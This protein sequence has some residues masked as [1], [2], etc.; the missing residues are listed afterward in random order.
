MTVETVN[1]I[2]DLNPAL[3]AATDARS[4]GDDHIRNLKTALVSTLGALA[5]P[6]TATHTELNYVDGVTSNIQ[7]QLDA[8]G[9]PV[10]VSS[11]FATTSGSS[12]SSGNIIP[13]SAKRVDVCV[14]GVSASG[15]TALR[16]RIGPSGGVATSGYTGWAVN[17]AGTTDAWSSSVPFVGTGVGAS[18]VV[19]AFFTMTLVDTNTWFISFNSTDDSDAVFGNGYVTLSGALTQVELSVASGTLDAGYFTVSYQ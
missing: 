7:T 15:T 2:A 9:P 3:P 10:T 17:D 19:Y 18:D 6:V 4:E 8:K 13:S 5:G 12:V 16:L 14:V 11:K 1:Y